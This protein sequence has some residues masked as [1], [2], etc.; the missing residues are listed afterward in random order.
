M[1]IEIVP[2]DYPDAADIAM[3]LRDSDVLE[4]QRLSGETPWPA[5]K[6]S[7]EGEGEAWIAK[8]DGVPEIVF[9]CG[10]ATVLRGRAHPWLLGTDMVERMAFPMLRTTKTFVERWAR[11]HTLLENLVDATNT[12]TIRWLKALGFTF[13]PPVEIRPKIMAQRFWMTGGGNV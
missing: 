7:I 1:N 5:I 12:R 13:D 9:G 10:R 3:R 2:A 11:E 4:L 6:Y 8:A